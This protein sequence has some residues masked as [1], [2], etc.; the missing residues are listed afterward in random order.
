MVKTE[1]TNVYLLAIVAIV[2]IVGIVVLILNSGINM[3]SGDMTGQG[4][5]KL[6]MKSVDITAK[7][8]TSG[9]VESTDSYMPD[10]TGTC[11]DSKGNPV[12]CA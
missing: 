6:N 3:V 7:S 10:C 4:Y 11:R 9:S 5:I 2:A 12:C 8:T 1:Q